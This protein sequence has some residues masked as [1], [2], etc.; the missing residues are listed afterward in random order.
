[1]FE[2][3]RS[4]RC[5]PSYPTE[6]N[7][8][9]I[10]IESTR[11]LPVHSDCER[12]EILNCSKRLASS[13]MLDDIEM[14]DCSFITIND[15]QFKPNFPDENE[16]DDI[17]I[18]CFINRSANKEKLSLIIDVINNPSKWQEFK[19]YVKK[20]GASSELTI[21][22]SIKKLMQYRGRTCTT[23]SKSLIKNIYRNNI[24][25]NFHVGKWMRNDTKHKLVDNIR[26]RRFTNDI[27]NE[28]IIDLI[29][30]WNDNILDEFLKIY[31]EKFSQKFLMNENVKKPEIHKNKMKTKMFLKNHLVNDHGVMTDTECTS[32]GNR[33]ME[34]LSNKNRKQKPINFN[35]L[36]Q[37]KLDTMDNGVM[38][39]HEAF[40]YSMN[41]KNDQA[42]LS[43]S[44]YP[45]FTSR[46]G[47]DLTSLDSLDHLDNIIKDDTTDGYSSD[48]SNRKW[49]T[50]TITD[51]LKEE[52]EKVEGS[53]SNDYHYRIARTN[54]N[55]F[56]KILS[57]RLSEVKTQTNEDEEHLD[58][59][60]SFTNDFFNSTMIGEEKKETTLISKMQNDSSSHEL[61]AGV[62]MAPFLLNNDDLMLTADDEEK[63]KKNKEKV[64]I[65]QDAENILNE[66]YDQVLCHNDENDSKIIYNEEEELMNETKEKTN[67]Y[68][69]SNFIESHEDYL[70]FTPKYN[71]QQ[72]MFANQFTNNNNNNNKSMNSE[73]RS[74]HK[75]SHDS[76]ISSQLFVNMD[77][78]VGSSLN[79][80]NAGLGST[81]KMEDR[82]LMSDAKVLYHMPN[83]EF[84]YVSQM[85]F[86]SKPY[87]SDFIK[88][89]PKKGNYRYFFKSK[90]EGLPSMSE[91][92]IALLEISDN[93]KPL[94]IV[95][96]LING[97]VFEKN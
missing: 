18:I 7:A 3:T 78:A 10:H 86:Y 93:S 28:V 19:N 38:S 23:E 59:Q 68:G 29:T 1:M 61:D 24:H 12:N 37:K 39:D 89:L 51:V 15:N 56:A 75:L 90:I 25:K 41:K 65:N 87:L 46:I 97:K 11:S 88:I 69:N 63:N 42:K 49:V 62:S 92:M 48:A 74:H 43:T 31:N 14:S 53:E 94:P 54:P 55:L 34:K 32:F 5:F 44:F 9:T 26:H 72:S 20:C 35:F 36:R 27:F 21:F 73:P 71:R 76:G 22:C 30:Y 60:T 50:S 2:F 70:K 83:E 57:D 40:R 91:P 77:S 67:Q 95:D 66:H 47:S 79:T 45:H 4:D 84:P 8:K 85:T 96:G 16:N 82:Q 64:D 33:L 58:Q 52:K 6:I 81:K 17:D 13:E 80:G